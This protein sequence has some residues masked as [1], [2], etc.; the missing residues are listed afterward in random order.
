[1]HLW[2]RQRAAHPADAALHATLAQPATAPGQMTP[3]RAAVHGEL[4]AG[5]NDPGKLK[6]AAALFGHEGLPEQAKALLAKAAHIHEMM[7]GAKDIVERSRAGDQHA[8][9]MAKAI[10][11]QAQAGSKRALLSAFLI[12]QY[13]K[14]HPAKAA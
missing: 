8:M 3:A 7:H 12:E 6:R 9:A 13:S 10:G 11:E 2:H 4:M 14:Q 5:C 1:M